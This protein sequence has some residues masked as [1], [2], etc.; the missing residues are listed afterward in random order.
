MCQ[1]TF[2]FRFINWTIAGAVPIK[3]LY[4]DDVAMEIERQILQSQ[5]FLF[6]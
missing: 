2:D 4:E 1:R 3:M 6:L 5:T